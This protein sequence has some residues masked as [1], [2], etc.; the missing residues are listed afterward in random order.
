MD[1]NFIIAQIFG[2][3][4]I[5][6]SVCSM[7]FKNR[8]TILIAL[9]CLNLFSALNLIFL[10][11]FSAAYITL[12]A[13]LEMIV[14]YLFERKK[15]STPKPVVVLY[16]LVNIA[17]GALTFAKPLDLLPLLAAIIFCFTVLTKDEQN[18][19]KLMFLNQ[20]LW[21]IFDLS[22]GAYVLLGSNI[23]TLVSTAT[24]LYRFRNKK[25]PAKA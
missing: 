1:Y 21:L 10:G 11:S 3:L 5:A 19:R 6:A 12:F 4:S 13:I 7:Q 14:N 9:L 8:K 24:A 15:K 23:L 16:I 2:G 17:L 25:S 18:I 22:V 20:S